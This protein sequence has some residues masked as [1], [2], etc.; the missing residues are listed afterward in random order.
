MSLDFFSTDFP[1]SHHGS[2]HHQGQPAC[3]LLLWGEPRDLTVMS[4][5]LTDRAVVPPRVDALCI[6][7]SQTVMNHLLL[8]TPGDR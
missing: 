1:S 4:H 2:P 5:G 8:S 7:V 6:R 3:F